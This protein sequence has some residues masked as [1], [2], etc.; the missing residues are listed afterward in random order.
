MNS[1]KSM[2]EIKPKC[3]VEHQSA[4]SRRFKKINISNEFNNRIIEN[5]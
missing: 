4:I 5:N 3:K 1:Q 2:D